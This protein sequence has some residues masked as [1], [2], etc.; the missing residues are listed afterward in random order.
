MSGVL[1]GSGRCVLIAAHG[2]AVLR[3]E[4]APGIEIAMLIKS[5]GLRNLAVR[6]IELYVSALL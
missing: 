4:S 5:Y 6:T 1:G 3:R 2:A